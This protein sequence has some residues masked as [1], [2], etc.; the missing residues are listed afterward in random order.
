MRTL[1]SNS[2]NYLNQEL[3]PE[4]PADPDDLLPAMTATRCFLFPVVNLFKNPRF[5]SW[6]VGERETPSLIASFTGDLSGPRTMVIDHDKRTFQHS[7]AAVPF[8]FKAFVF[9]GRNPSAFWR[10]T[11]EHV[12]R[13]RKMPRHELEKKVG[14]PDLCIINARNK[15]KCQ[16]GSAVEIARIAKS[17]GA[18]V[19]AFVTLPSHLEKTRHLRAQKGLDK[20]RQYAD[21][22]FVL[23]LNYL[24]KM[25][26]KDLPLGYVYQS[27]IRS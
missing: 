10:R 27:Q 3:D 24:L 8:F 16:N 2:I 13:Q 22:V 18:V 19:T 14:T 5:S 6:D 7:H 21:S 1:I 17:P 11:S 26:P 20:H 23:D 9:T 15:Q 4:L 25:T 12:L